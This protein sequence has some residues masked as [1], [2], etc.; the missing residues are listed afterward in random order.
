MIFKKD[1]I[2][3]I[4]YGEL[5][6]QVEHMIKLINP[7]KKIAYF[8]DNFNN[9]INC[10]KFL[11]YSKSEFMDYKFIVCLGYKHLKM[12]NEIINELMSLKRTLISVIHPNTYIDPSSNIGLGNI[13]YPG[14]I[15]DKN[16]KIG[17]GNVLNLSSIISHDTTIANTCF[18]APGTTVSGCVNIGSCTFIGAGSTISNSISIGDDC[19]IGIGSVIT[20]NINNHSKVIGNPQKNVDTL[21]LF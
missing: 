21:E 11:D 10:Y 13:L 15:V 2:G 18:I 1:Y 7:N 16:V 3:I 5:G 6:K 4:G 12:K 14:V 9:N 20:K 8:D 17:H 19:I